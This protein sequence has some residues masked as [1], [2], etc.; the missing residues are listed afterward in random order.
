MCEI[1]ELLGRSYRGHGRTAL[2]WRS[3]WPTCSLGSTYPA[4]SHSTKKYRCNCLTSYIQGK[5][6]QFFPFA[7]NQVFVDTY[8]L[9]TIIE[10][11]SAYFHSPKTTV[12][13]HKKIILW[14]REN[15]FHL[16][17]D[18]KLWTFKITW[19]H[20]DVVLLASVIEFGKPP[21][22]ET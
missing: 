7:F 19:S 20:T 16:V 15:L 8:Y 10:E 2:F 11:I 22:N 21:I 4:N 12:M 9:R 5:L 18:E 14:I 13:N 17:V 3:Y 6:K 1:K